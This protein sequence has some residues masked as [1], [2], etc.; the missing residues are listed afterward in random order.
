MAI[1]R[2]LGFCFSSRKR[3]TR[4]ALVTGFQTCALPIAAKDVLRDP[5]VA[6]VSRRPDR[7]GARAFDLLDARALGLVRHGGDR[8]HRRRAPVGPPRPRAADLAVFH[9]GKVA[10]E[11]VRDLGAPPLP[12]SGGV[13]WTLHLV[14]TIVGQDRF[15]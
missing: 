7:T 15:T 6:L 11:A 9:A 14:L 10:S 12:L 4:C 5:G 1:L 8:A 2:D 3:H 13:Y